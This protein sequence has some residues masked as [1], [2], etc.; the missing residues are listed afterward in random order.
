MLEK[1]SLL[2]AGEAAQTQMSG[3]VIMTT[4]VLTAVVIVA[5]S[6]LVVSAMGQSASDAVETEFG[7]GDVGSGDVGS[8]DVGSGEVSARQPVYVVPMNP[9]SQSTRRRSRELQGEDSD[10]WEDWDNDYYGRGPPGQ[11]TITWENTCPKSRLRCKSRA[12]D[13]V[14]VSDLL[15][16]SYLVGTG[17]DAAFGECSANWPIVSPYSVFATG[18]ILAKEFNHLVPRLRG[19]IE[20]YMK[21]VN[22]D[23]FGD[24]M[25]DGDYSTTCE[26]SNY[27][28]GDD[29]TCGLQY[30][31][32]AAA[33]SGDECEIL[34]KSTNQSIK[35]NA[36][37]W[38]GGDNDT[39][40]YHYVF[41]DSA[42]IDAELKKMRDECGWNMG[43]LPMFDALKKF[44][45]LEQKDAF[46][47]FEVDALIDVEPSR[48][49]GTPPHPLL[50]R[51]QHFKTADQLTEECKYDIVIA[52]GSPT[53]D[54]PV[55]VV[56]DTRFVGEN[57]N[58]T[59]S[60][61]QLD[62]YGFEYSA[63]NN[64]WHREGVAGCDKGCCDDCFQW[65]CP[66]YKEIK[67][68]G[69]KKQFN[70]D[71]SADLPYDCTK[72][73]YDCTKGAETDYN[74]SSAQV[75][76]VETHENYVR[77]RCL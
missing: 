38:G 63:Q 66:I 8:G 10:D 24:M 71:G 55:V 75:C 36:S 57:F 15:E 4:F 17:Y 74:G 31:E 52:I 40:G 27:F 23:R 54:S 14:D 60:N 21:S 33:Y 39:E 3:V 35:I 26:D 44:S 11:P 69:I 12:D 25:N 6:L 42:D 34:R 61:Y 29:Y 43:K 72:Y 20:N 28:S 67:R 13:W 56:N 46:I 41:D 65:Y 47:K 48:D 32:M 19:R 68:D 58:G 64:L 49:G 16:L 70:R 5:S 45:L 59:K 1:R 50:G 73:T 18:G 9:D 22:I 53:C 7:S 62:K 51:L 2:R 30:I 37:Q 76:G 77:Y